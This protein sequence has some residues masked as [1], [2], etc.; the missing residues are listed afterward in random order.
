MVFW[1]KNE[2]SFFDYFDEH[3]AFINAAAKVLQRLLSEESPSSDFAKCIKKYEHSAD[4]ITHQLFRQ[5]NTSGFILP[6]DREDVLAMTKKL[7]D[8]I[9]WINNAAQ[10]YSEIYEIQSPTEYSKNF[11]NL[12]YES[13]EILLLLCQLIRKPAHNSSLILQKCL[14]IHTHENTGDDVKKA[15]LKD[16]YS[17]LK[18][19]E[20]DLPLYLAWDEIYRIL[21]TVTDLV[22][23]CANVAEQIV[24]KY[25]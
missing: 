13:S 12:I 6:M 15:A 16:L 7:D 21:E 23:D 17:K 24:M 14:A 8:V 19:N 25:S 2:K 5:M 10:A 22:E 11:G 18:N 20:I 4:E 3:A 9:D 1:N